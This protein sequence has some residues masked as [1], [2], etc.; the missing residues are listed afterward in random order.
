MEVTP[1][2]MRSPTMNQLLHMNWLKNC[3]N[4]FELHTFSEVMKDSP[5]VVEKKQGCGLHNQI[6][7]LAKQLLQQE[8]YTH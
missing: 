1:I 8:D 7:R 2:F 6:K 3:K 4:L 5:Q